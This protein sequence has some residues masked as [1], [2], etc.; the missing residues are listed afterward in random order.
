[1]PDPGAPTA[2]NRCARRMETPRTSRRAWPSACRPL[3]A[4]ARSE[5]PEGER[6]EDEDDAEQQHSRC[7]ALARLLELEEPLPDEPDERGRRLVRPALGDDVHR[8]EHLEVRD[9]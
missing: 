4:A 2:R 5:Q 1:M 9:D 3:V 8:V 7:K 6:R